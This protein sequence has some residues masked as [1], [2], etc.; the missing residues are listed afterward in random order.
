M[1]GL[2]R[3]QATQAIR[4]LRVKR[5]ELEETVQT[6]IDAIQVLRRR[7]GRHRKQAAEWKSVSRRELSERE[8]TIRNLVR[9]RDAYVLSQ[10]AL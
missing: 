5:Q 8:Q 1:I 2:E 6:Q 10:P 7:V 4:E 9:E 3:L